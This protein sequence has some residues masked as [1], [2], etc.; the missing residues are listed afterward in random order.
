MKLRIL[1]ASLL[2]A[3]IAPAFTACYEDK[4]NYEYSDRKSVV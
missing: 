4:G 1:S 3:A 2:L